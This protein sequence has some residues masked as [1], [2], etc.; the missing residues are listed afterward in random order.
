MTVSVDRLERH[1]KRRAVTGGG[2]ILLLPEE[3]LCQAP[4]DEPGDGVAV[5][6][7]AVAVAVAGEERYAA[8]IFE[9]QRWFQECERRA[10]SQGQSGAQVRPW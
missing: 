2:F 8:D 3:G 1:A 4:G 10:G 5:A 7:V 9:Q 6:V